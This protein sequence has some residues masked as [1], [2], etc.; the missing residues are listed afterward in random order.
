MRL[1]IFIMAL[2]TVT[3]STGVDAQVQKPSPTSVQDLEQS[4]I[5]RNEHRAQSLLHGYSV[6]NVGPVTMSGRVSDIAVHPDTA[7]IFYVGFGSAGVFKTTNGGITME[8]I[9]DNQGGALGVGDI[10]ISPSNPN[11]LWVG[12]GENNSSRSTYAGTGVYKSVDAGK[13]WE[14]MGLRNTQH[15]GRILVH[16]ENPDIVWV[17][18]MGAL[19]SRN[20]ERGLYKT[21]DGGITWEKTLFINNNTGIIDVIMK[22]GD[23]DVLW[24]AAWE[25]SRE[26]WNFVESGEGS[27]IYVSKDGGTTWEASNDG[28]PVGA[29]LGRIGLSIS[30]NNPNRIYALID[31][32]D[33]RRIET[34]TNES[35]GLTS[36]SFRSMS[37]NELLALTDGEL[38]RFL[39]SNGFDSKYTAESIKKSVE[40]GDYEPEAIANYLGDANAELFDTEIIGAEVYRS[41]DNGNSWNKTHEI[42][43]DNV[44]FTYGYY[45]GEIRVDPSNA[46]TLYIM[47]V[48]ILKSTD[49]G[50]NWTPIAE[51]QGIHVD[52]QAL[53]INPKDGEHLLLGNDGGLYESKDGGQNFI[54]HNVAPVGQFYTVNVDMDTPYNI[55]GGLQDNGT[56]RG[57][58]RSTPNRE[59]PWTRL[60]GGDGMHVNPHPENSDIVYVGFQYGNYMRRNLSD[61]SSYRITPR[62]EI[63]EDRYRYNWNT[64][65]E[66]SVH[67]PEIVYFGSQRLNRSFDEGKTWTAISPDLS[68]NFANGDVPYS[69]ITSIAESPISFQVLWVGTDDGKVQVTRDGGTTWNDVSSGLPQYRWVSEVHASNHD[70]A[71]AYVSLNGYRFDE[72]SSYIF[73]TTDYGATWTSVTGDLPEDVVN[74]IVQDPVQPELIYAGLDHGSYVS[75]ND[76]QNWHLI[77]QIPNVASYDM[78]VHPRDLELVTATHGR[79][80]YVSDVTLFHELHARIQ[81]DIT[82]FSIDDVRYSARWGNQSV[83]YRDAFEPNFEASFYVKPKNNQRLEWVTLEV[84][85]SNEDGNV[86][87]DEMRVREGLNTFRWNL[88]HEQTQE[89]LGKGSYTLTIKKGRS[90]HETT[91]EIK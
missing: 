35:R 80:I 46:N 81:E 51:N 54:H 73:K 22:P 21:T 63:G 32:Q 2:L 43:L 42:A 44:Y 33:V 84:M 69:T 20:D 86:Y 11:I 58:S 74:V 26:A 8:P 79:S 78:I 40:K 57:S 1:S 85:V 61:G 62:H 9:F 27:G 77:T 89:Y 23:A 4:I 45:F 16:P 6:R 49:A 65:V 87:T 10:A 67:N 70:V 83:A 47:G 30:P 55:Y 39:R 3:L 12:T 53:W 41:D 56:W 7:R 48:P 25:R 71:T 66:L 31:N 64:P 18:S 88:F 28:L 50:L 82:V 52:H 38:N 34:S 75:L 29:T 14:F 59:R 19:Y 24:A 36:E 76:G 90:S 17:A 5:N 37:K 13:T 60:F 68:Y 72:F 91:F 15:I